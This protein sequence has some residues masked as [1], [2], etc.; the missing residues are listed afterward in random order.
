MT[1]PTE[2]ATAENERGAGIGLREFAMAGAAGLVGTDVYVRLG[3]TTTVTVAAVVC[4]R[5]AVAYR[6]RRAAAS[7]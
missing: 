3:L 1:S 2:T 4:L 6:D 5:A 7:A